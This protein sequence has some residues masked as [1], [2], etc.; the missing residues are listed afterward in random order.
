MDGE[1]LPSFI[2][3]DLIW[4]K[5]VLWN[6]LQTESVII[7]AIPFAFFIN[8]ILIE[9]TIQFVNWLFSMIAKSLFET[10]PKQPRITWHHN[11]AQ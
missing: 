9:I 11:A 5:I 4:I 2:S 3:R 10:S 1:L 7:L 8:C 6:Y